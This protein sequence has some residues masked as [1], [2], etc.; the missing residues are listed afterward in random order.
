MRDL[1]M[2]TAFAAIALQNDTEIYRTEPEKKQ[3]DPDKINKAKGLKKFYYGDNFVWATN[4]K[5]A[6]R[7]AKQLNYI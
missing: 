4:Q 6:D 3:K 2:F 7:K 1:A 5:N